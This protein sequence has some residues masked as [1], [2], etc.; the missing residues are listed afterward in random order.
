MEVT[1]KHLLNFTA[2]LQTQEG[3]EEEGG[4]GKKRGRGEETP[5][6]VVRV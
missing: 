5:R 6:R 4:Q 1:A 3:G 2:K